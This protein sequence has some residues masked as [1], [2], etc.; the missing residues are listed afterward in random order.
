M[1][2]NL[3]IM[4]YYSLCFNF[5]SIG[6]LCFTDFMEVVYLKLAEKDTRDEIYKAFTL[7]DKERTGFI[8]FEN[9]RQV[10]IELGEGKPGKNIYLSISII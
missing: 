6:K 2:C 9:L 1:L 4:I 10:A 3:I 7:F 5:L 8:T